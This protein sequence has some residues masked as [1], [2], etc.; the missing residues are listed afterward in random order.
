MSHRNLDLRLIE[1][2]LSV[3]VYRKAEIIKVS[4]IKNTVTDICGHRHA[5]L[6]IEKVGVDCSHR[7]TR[8]VCRA[9]KQ[10]LH[11]FCRIQLFSRGKIYLGIMSGR[12]LYLICTLITVGIVFENG[13]RICNSVGYR[14]CV[15]RYLMCPCGIFRRDCRKHRALRKKCCRQRKGYC[16]YKGFFYVFIHFLCLRKRR[17]GFYSLK[18]I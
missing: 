1:K 18:S 4:R 14:I 2:R 12:I 13:L 6:G 8:I 17:K 11:G 3:I 10:R 9:L 16:F 15:F 7:S 5:G